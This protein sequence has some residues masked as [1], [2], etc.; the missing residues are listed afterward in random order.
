[1]SDNMRSRPTKREWGLFS[2]AIGFVLCGLFILPSDR[3]VGIVTIALFGSAAVVFV[4][5]L[6]RKL[7]RRGSP[8]LRVDITGGVPIKAAHTIP[9]IAGTWLVALGMVMIVFS[10]SYGWVM[11]VLGAVVVACGGAVL[12]AL[13][14]GRLPNRYLQFDPAGITF[15]HHRWSYLVEWDNIAQVVAGE[16]H[17]NPIVLIVLDQPDLVDVHPQECRP[18]VFKLL[19]RNAAWLNAHVV[20][21]PA[22]FRM[23]IHLLTPALERYIA[24]PSA[25]AE[26][27]LRRLPDAIGA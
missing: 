4:I 14:T 9:A 17:S 20:L 10:Q 21:S 16:L 18:Q 22:Q 6:W 27:A 13:A 1:M 12:L 2:T 8:T 7:R 19:A 11:V 3:D 25:R 5:P 26:L 15:G 23:D 24:D